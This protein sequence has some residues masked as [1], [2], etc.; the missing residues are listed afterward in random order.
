MDGHRALTQDEVDILIAQGCSAT[1]WGG[2]TVSAEFA[3]GKIRFVDFSGSVR[4]GANTEICQARIKDTILGANSVVRNIG[5]IIDNCEVGENVCIE[6]VSAVISEESAACGVGIEVK[7]INESG[8][9]EV[10][11]HPGLSAQSAYLQAFVSSNSFRQA[12]RKLLF[13][14]LVKDSVG[15]CRIGEG[16]VI[17]DA[18]EIKNSAV[19]REAIIEGAVRIFNS[20]VNGRVG[21]GSVVK[22]SIIA[23]NGYVGEGCILDRCFVADSAVLDSGF[24]AENS[25][26]FANSECLR[27]E[28]CSVF[29]G[30]FTSSHHKSTL[31]LAGVYSFYTAGS[32]S[33][34]SNHRFKLGPLHQGILERGSKTGSSSYLIW[35]SQLAPFT[36]VIG[37]HGRVVDTG[38]FPF[39]LL[40]A[41]NDK[42]VLLPGALIFSCGY[43]R[44][45]LKW[46]A[47]DKRS[48][49]SYDIIN[50]ELLNP[51]TVGK[52]LHAI[53]LLKEMKSGK[54]VAA[55][56]GVEIPE[57]FIEKAI[58]RYHTGVNYYYGEVV[59]GVLENYS[60]KGTGLLSGSSEGRNEEWVD[61]VGLITPKKFIELLVSGVEGGRIT[62]YYAVQEFFIKLDKNYKTYEWDWVSQ[63]FGDIDLE[64]D[65]CRENLREILKNWKEAAML[66]VELVKRDAYKEFTENM[67]IGYGLLEAKEQDFTNIRGYFDDNKFMETVMK[68]TTSTFE[69]AD[70][71]LE[72]INKI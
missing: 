31:L 68:Q 21:A 70:R 35:P 6:N 3:T 29:A 2:V 11:L 14:H 24:S 7:V 19:G 49:A 23:V 12:Y 61:L 26:F 1:S 44:D 66:R 27:G 32:G 48:G 39:S 69:R 63:R 62:D 67:S 17:K 30:P 36:S 40:L 4:I 42:S 5:R 46:N 9:R 43:V 37:R 56:V 34:F 71:L 53:R 65:E 20:T 13:G 28:G 33:N 15:R 22:N 64:R 18:G 59:A 41:E 54:K 50:T 10:L 25:L 60:K 58:A 47:R 57:E 16:A 52:I 45:A 38:N 51:Y 72:L 55:A 8:G